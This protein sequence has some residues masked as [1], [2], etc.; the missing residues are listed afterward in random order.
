MTSH[1]IRV[2]TDSGAN[3]LMPGIKVHDWFVGLALRDSQCNSLFSDSV[4]DIDLDEEQN[5]QRK[6]DAHN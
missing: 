5:I 4:L 6:G 3:C 1:V 2:R